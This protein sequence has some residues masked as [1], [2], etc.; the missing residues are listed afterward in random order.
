M[1]SLMFINEPGRDLRIGYSPRRLAFRKR[2]LS[3]GGVYWPP[4]ESALLLSLL[5]LGMCMM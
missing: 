1:H 5:L 2:G 3:V 4:D